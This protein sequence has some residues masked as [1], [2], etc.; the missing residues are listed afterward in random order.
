MTMQG[1]RFDFT[2]IFEEPQR[3][4]TVEVEQLPHQGPGLTASWSRGK[5]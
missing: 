5:V 3:D 4:S 2:I 1:R